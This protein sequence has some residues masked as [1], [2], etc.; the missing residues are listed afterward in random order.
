MAHVL[1]VTIE[2]TK[3]SIDLDRLTF[4][5]GRAIEKVT[6]SDF[7]DVVR[8]RSLTGVQALVWVTVKRTQPMLKFSD[9]DDWAINDVDFDMNADEPDPTVPVEATAG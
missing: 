5:E 9:L 1:T 6:G 8:M 7:G 2:G 4:A 3:H